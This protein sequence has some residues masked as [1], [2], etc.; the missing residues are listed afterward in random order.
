M[1]RLLTLARMAIISW[2]RRAALRARDYCIAQA[3]QADNSA[4]YHARRVAALDIALI[5][6]RRALDTGSPRHA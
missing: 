5:D 2:R 3:A 1:T 6:A 4:A